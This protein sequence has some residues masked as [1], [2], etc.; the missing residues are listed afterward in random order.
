[1]LGQEISKTSYSLLLLSYQLDI[2]MRRIS[3]HC[4]HLYRVMDSF[5][6]GIAAAA[7]CKLTWKE[8]RVV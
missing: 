1:M 6:K 4:F 8:A 7:V 5:V 2:W 3:I